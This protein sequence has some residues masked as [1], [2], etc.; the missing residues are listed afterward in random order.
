MLHLDISGALA[1]TVTPSMGIPDQE[2]TALRSGM[3]RYVEDFLAE[4]R[5]AEHGWT[6]NPYDRKAAER[7]KE[8]AIVAK[9]MGIKTVVWIGIGGSGLGPRV[10]QEVFEGPDTL[11]FV[12]LDTIDPSILLLALETIDWRQTLVVIASK[13]GDTLEPMSV[14]ALCWQKLRE[15]RKGSAAER[16]I[17]ITDPEKGSLREFC[18]E[19]GISMLP[20]PSD[21]GGRYSIF[22]PIGLL[23]MALLG[24]DVNAFLRGAKEMDT[25][26]QETNFEDNPAAL[27]A[28]VQFLLDTRRGYSNRVIM[29][30]AQKL[31]SVGRWDQQLIAESL[32]KKETPNP[33]PIAA[34]GT[35]DQHSLLQQ[36]M[37]GPRKCW[38]IFIRDIEKP[39][40]QVPEDIGG[41]FTYLG[42]KSF[43]Q[44]LDACY[45]GTSRALTSAKRP[46]VTISLTRTDSNHLGQLFFL[47]LCE[48]VFLGKLYR[49]DPYGQP[50]VEIGKKITKEILA[51]GREE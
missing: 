7:V 39:R 34:I 46:H 8:S 27:L 15:A 50:A 48:V 35:Q 32:G 26:C 42:G 13:S 9:A 24:G 3:K 41:A 2:I 1:K 22:T 47:F 30:Y 43:G 12:L 18:L 21:V 23:P 37:A 10:I 16:V 28:G 11:E 25:L 20:L 14:F 5:D 33:L 44:L 45:E 4:R 31:E 40:V 49:I 36:W 29:P 6:M 17:A 51:R 19:H 38:H